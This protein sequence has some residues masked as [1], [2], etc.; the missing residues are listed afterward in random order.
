MYERHS[1]FD[2]RPGDI[3]VPEPLFYPSKP[4]PLQS[5]WCVRFAAAGGAWERNWSWD[6]HVWACSSTDAVARA[7][8]DFYASWGAS[9]E[10]RV[11]YPLRVLAVM[12]EAV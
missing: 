8:A 6:T 9:Y 1:R 10:D 11:N 12:Q 7:R 4:V 3:K 5:R 2:T